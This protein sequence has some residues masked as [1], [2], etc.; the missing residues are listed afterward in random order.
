MYDISV[1]SLS[2]IVV[3]LGEPDGNGGVSPGAS[4]VFEPQ[5]WSADTDP[6]RI[7]GGP[8][9]S[10]RIDL[11]GQLVSR[12]VRRP[13]RVMLAVIPGTATDCRLK[14]ALYASRSLTAG[15]YLVSSILFRYGSYS[16]VVVTD[17]RLVD[18]PLGL[19][20]SSDGRLVA[21]PYVF[22]FAD[23]D[24]EFPDDGIVQPAETQPFA[25]FGES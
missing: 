25:G 15:D 4:V 7:V 18:G 8:V 2:Q 11:N 10:S 20:F 6:V 21:P 13:I 22:E 17:G 5:D 16:R 24:G 1:Q 9:A 3:T 12:V 19:D 23:I 14:N